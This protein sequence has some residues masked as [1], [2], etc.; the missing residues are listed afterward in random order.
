MLIETLSLLDKVSQKLSFNI[1]PVAAQSL[2]QIRKASEHI[3]ID[4]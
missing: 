4:V 3:V 2:F 1:F